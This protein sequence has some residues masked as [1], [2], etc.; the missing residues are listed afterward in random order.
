MKAPILDVLIA[1]GE[2][3]LIPNLLTNRNRWEVPRS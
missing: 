3:W 1:T 2:P